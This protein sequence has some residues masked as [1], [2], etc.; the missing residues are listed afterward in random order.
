[1]TVDLNTYKVNKDFIQKWYKSNRNR[2]VT[3]VISLLSCSTFVPCIVVAFYIGE[4][5]GWSKEVTE[6]IDRLTKFYSY[7]ILNKPDSYPRK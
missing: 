7:D 5:N 3:Y 4:V 6:C 1:M 2:D